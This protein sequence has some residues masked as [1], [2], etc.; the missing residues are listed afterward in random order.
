MLKLTDIIKEKNLLFTH[1]TINNHSPSTFKDF[2]TFNKTE[3]EH[4]TV[5]SL[6]S[7][8]SIPTGSLNLPTHKTNAGK[9]SIRY[10]CCS[11]WNLILKDLSKKYVDKYK[12]DPYWINN[13]SVKVIKQILKEHFLEYY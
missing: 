6:N 2:F 8:Y 10:I 12:K 1:N 7:N 9:T 4:H 11:T 5:N 13:T 3:H